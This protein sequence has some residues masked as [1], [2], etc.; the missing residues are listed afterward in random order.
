MTMQSKQ[1]QLIYEYK[2]KLYA[3]KVCSADDVTHKE[4]A[5]FSKGI[6]EPLGEK[7]G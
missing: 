4:Y 2:R 7:V 1:E 3:I 6:G 5:S